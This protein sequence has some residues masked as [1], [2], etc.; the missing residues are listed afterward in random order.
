MK[1]E[2]TEHSTRASLSNSKLV[3]RVCIHCTKKLTEAV[4][5]RFHDRLNP[6]LEEDAMCQAPNRITTAG[7]S[8]RSRRTKQLRHE[9]G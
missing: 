9:P 8:R 5:I 4:E 6:Y 3:S 2:D 1:K 7:L